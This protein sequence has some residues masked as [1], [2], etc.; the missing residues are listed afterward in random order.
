METPD[1]IQYNLTFRNIKLAV[2]ICWEMREKMWL[3]KTEL[4]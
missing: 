3:I 1:S 2:V 4:S